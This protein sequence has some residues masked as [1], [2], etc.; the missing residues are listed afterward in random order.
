MDKKLSRMLLVFL[1]SAPMLTLLYGGCDDDGGG[2]GGPGP[3]A[4]QVQL[5]QTQCKDVG[6]GAP[7]QVSVVA[8]DPNGDPLTFE[9]QFAVG[10][11]GLGE[12]PGGAFGVPAP[13]LTG[14]DTPDMSLS[15]LLPLGRLWLT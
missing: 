10:S 5:D 12:W 14:A 11:G 15:L 6:F 8:T 3:G 9:W 7:S 13:A 1:L 4:P 2:G